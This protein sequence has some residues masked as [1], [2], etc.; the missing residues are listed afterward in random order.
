MVKG[1]IMRKG[2][3]WR[4]FAGTILG[5]AG[6]M[7]LFDAIWAWTY[8][9][10]LPDNLEDAIFG[11]QL[12]TY[13]WIYMVVG[14]VLICCSFGVMVGSELSRWIGIAAGGLLAV[15]SIWWMPY[16]PIWSLTYV[17][18]GTLVIYALATYG[19]HKTL[20]EAD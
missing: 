17:A 20:D 10:P 1:A 2:D 5:V 9:G 6:V 4:F 11:H 15:T 3:G 16:Y 14:V 7:R 13:G 18:L 12:T 19:G 8:S